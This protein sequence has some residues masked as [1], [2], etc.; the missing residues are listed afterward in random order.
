MSTRDDARLTAQE[1][2][3]FA[4]LEAAAAADD[5]QLAKR[6]RG[7]N[8]I[9][10]RSVLTRGARLASE[11]WQRLLHLGWWGAPLAVVGL[12]LVVVSM[13]VGLALGVVGALISTLGLYLVAR[14]VRDRR[15]AT[16]EPD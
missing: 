1:R 11:W 12:L 14:T 13:S 2:A 9:W 15:A 6:L 10:V 8:G 4:G 3:A 5:P 16:A 7:S